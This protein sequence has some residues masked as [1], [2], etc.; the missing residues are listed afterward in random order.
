M[1]TIINH[2]AGRTKPKMKVIN[3]FFVISTKSTA[4]QNTYVNIDI[5]CTDVQKIKILNQALNFQ[6]YQDDFRPEQDRSS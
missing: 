1:K 5:D 4:L 3:I 6:I 2:S